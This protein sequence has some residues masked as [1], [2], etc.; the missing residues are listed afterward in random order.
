MNLFPVPVW[1]EQAHFTAGL[2]E[3]GSKKHPSSGSPKTLFTCLWGK[4]NPMMVPWL[5]SSPPAWIRHWFDALLLSTCSDARSATDWNQ[6]WMPQCCRRPCPWS[7]SCGEG[8]QIL[9]YK[10]NSSRTWAAAGWNEC[11]RRFHEWVKLSWWMI[12]GS[13]ELQP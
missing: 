7:M 5:F 2:A 4:K 1:T 9:N 8:E 3:T 13:S 6:C 11:K 10:E 12:R